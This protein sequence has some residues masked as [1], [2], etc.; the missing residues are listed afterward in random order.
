MRR[1]VPH[2][3]H[4]TRTLALA[5]P[6]A[7]VQLGLQAMPLVDTIVSG[8]VSAAVQAG[9]AM[10]A[11][12][13]LVS[14]LFGM[15]VLLA[16]DPVVA[17]AAG[18][19]EHERVG[20]AL[21]RGLVLAALMSVPVA[22]LHLP[23]ERVLLAL[24]QPAGVARAAGAYARLSI[25]GIPAFLGYVALKQTLQAL[26]TTRP[27]V[28][29]IVLA[30]LLNLFLDVALIGGEFGFPALGVNGAAIA[31][32]I[33]RWFLIG[34]LAA[35]AW[36]LVARHLR[37]FRRAAL[38]RAALLRLMRIGVPIGMTILLEFAGFSTVALLM[39]IL[40]ERQLAA[41]QVAISVVSFTYMIP[42]GVAAAASVLV[43]NAIGRGDDDDARRD[44]GAALFL[45]GGVM[46]VTGLAYALFPEP[47]ARFASNDE[48]VIAIAATLLPIA[49]VF[50]VADG[51]Q[52]VAAGALRGVGDTRVPLL[53]GFA[54]YWCVG[55]PLSVFLGVELGLG[56]PGLWWGL[57]GALSVSA[58]LLVSRTFLLLRAPQIRVDA[59][60]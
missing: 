31:T 50:Q 49:G 19:G 32:T 48:H 60:D 57:V 13:S 28:I 2:R 42:L 51:L 6:V 35:L 38:Q 17:Q 44:A 33:G 4:L 37:P 45:G 5:V 41:H 52:C 36:P 7:A 21:Q 30:N 40:G 1:F 27:I 54:A 39:G 8:R 55:L 24:G 29:S 15:G 46:V 58:A 18:A 34:S 47:I 26:H 12:Y 53:M 59:G 16:L 3:S 14:L 22:L 25:P 10:G 23:A 9:T 20:L 43:G 11:Y 56:P